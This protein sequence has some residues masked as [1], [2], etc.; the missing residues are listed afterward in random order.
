[1]PVT[2]TFPKVTMADVPAANE[3]PV[4]LTAVCGTP[5]TV[6]LIVALFKA[7]DPAFDSSNCT[8]SVLP[9]CGNVGT[10]KLVIAASSAAG[11]NSYTPGSGNGF[12][13]TPVISSVTPVEASPWLLMMPLVGIAVPGWKKGSVAKLF[14]SSQLAVDQSDS[15]GYKFTGGLAKVVAL[16]TATFPAGTQNTLR[17]ETKELVALPFAKAIAALHAVAGR[18]T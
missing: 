16:F 12:L 6:Q 13:V 8:S 18:V 3:G 9:Q 10:I 2:G 1:M 17:S 11:E 7:D 5:F 15:V 4:Q 14:T